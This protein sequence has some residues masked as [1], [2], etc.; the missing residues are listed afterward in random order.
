MVPSQLGCQANREIAVDE[1]PADAV[2]V[3]CPSCPAHLPSLP[4]LEPLIKLRAI[5]QIVVVVVSVI[6][7]H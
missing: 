5:K 3:L 6:A 1:T 7:K 4:G 2:P